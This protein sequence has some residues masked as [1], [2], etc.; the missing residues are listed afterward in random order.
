MISL[1]T[2]VLEGRFFFFN[3]RF[4]TLKYREVIYPAQSNTARKSQNLIFTLS[5]PR[6]SLTPLRP[7]L[8]SCWRKWCLRNT[9]IPS[10]PA[11]Q[12]ESRKEDVCGD[13]ALFSALSPFFPFFLGKLSLIH[14]VLENL[15]PPSTWFW[16]S[17]AAVT[18]APGQ[19]TQARAILEQHSF[20]GPQR[21]VIGSSCKHVTQDG[22]SEFSSGPEVGTKKLSRSSSAVRLRW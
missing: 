8:Y 9:Q 4:T 20:T 11:R 16:F 22:Q 21:L 2:T 10:Q 14:I 3:L 6:P 5:K 7:Q 13:R 12:A 17:I 19:M 1:G 18:C 15:L